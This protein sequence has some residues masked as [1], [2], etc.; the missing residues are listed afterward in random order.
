VSEAATERTEAL[1][2][3]DLAGP[4][5]RSPFG[6][7]TTAAEDAARALFESTVG[8]PGDAGRRRS[9]HG[10]AEAPGPPPE[11]AISL[12][13][14]RQR[15]ALQS[16]Q[17]AR[18]MEEVEAVNRRLQSTRVRAA[19]AETA[20][21]RERAL[22]AR[23]SAQAAQRLL[24]HRR[25]IAELAGRVEAECRAA[26]AGRARIAQLEGRLEGRVRMEGSV[27]RLIARTREAIVEVR[28][29]L[30]RA[31][32]RAE[33]LESA[34]AGERRV[35]FALERRLEEATPEAQATR[36]GASGPAPQ[37]VVWSDVATACRRLEQ[38]L[39]TRDAL[40]LKAA[41]LIG[42]LNRHFDAA[43]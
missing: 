40:E 1:G 31:G 29:E 37:A 19:S 14:L 27:T 24:E 10:G 13:E 33:H 41:R 36:V 26:A 18:A 2:D 17:L 25:T 16:G 22:R 35:R 15:V 9:G 3:E 30:A 23:N 20:A 4:R 39:A 43:R 42:S 5:R 34:L 38:E 21:A 7:R 12:S 32:Q 8:A 28:T 11:I 6:G